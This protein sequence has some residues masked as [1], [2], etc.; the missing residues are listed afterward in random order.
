[1]ELRMQ[2]FHTQMAFNNALTSPSLLEL[3]PGKARN[4]S[5]FALI[6][7]QPSKQT[8]G[9]ECCILST[10]QQMEVF[11]KRSWILCE[12]QGGLL[13]RHSP[14]PPPL[15]GP[16]KQ[17]LH[18]ISGAQNCNDNSV[19][20]QAPSH[21]IVFTECA[22]LLPFNHCAVVVKMGQ[23]SQFASKAGVQLRT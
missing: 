18:R 17:D 22:Y 10:G 23:H 9:E 16:N 20:F 4:V 19:E 6:E 14:M 1:M 12:P 3:I 11:A 5:S 2:M 13:C 7:S 8:H 15:R 21:Q